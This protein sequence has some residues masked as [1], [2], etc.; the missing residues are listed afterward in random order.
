MRARCS[1]ITVAAQAGICAMT[2]LAAPLTVLFYDDRYN[3]T[4]DRSVMPLYRSLD[5]RLVPFL[6]GPPAGTAG[7]GI[8]SGRPG[9][10]PAERSLL[11]YRPGLKI[12]WLMGSALP[13]V[14]A[15]FAL[16]LDTDVVWLCDAK[17]VVAKRT[18]L[19]ADRQVRDD[20]VILFGEKGMWPPY[21][22]FHGVQLRA[23]AT[24]GYPPAKP[25]APF[26]FI[27]A[28]AALGRPHDLLAMYRCMK[29]RYA[30]FPNACPAGH[31]PDGALRYYQANRSWVPP[32]L[33]QPSR[34]TKFHGMALRG[35]NWGWEQGCFHMYYLE[36][37][38]GE[39]PDS[40]P[41][42]ELDRA[43]KWLLHL[44]GVSQ[45]SLVWTRGQHRAPADGRRVGNP[46]VTLRETGERPCALHANGPAK[47][48]LSSIWRW[49]N[50]PSAARPGPK[51]KGKE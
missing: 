28:G 31:G 36:Q 42:I 33:I 37:L 29:Q 46:R 17:E 39:L 23:N 48:M 10:G 40:C 12:D 16:L 47:A 2:T 49:W 43:G 21:Q 8:G 7:A 26:R 38:A 5:S 25:D 1:R 27:N 6:V 14:A 32:L 3:E 34:L 9:D 11:R 15:E 19:I 13:S 44:A 35:S 45:Q 18:A 41:P 51:H 22:E 50:D 4:R 20:S 24:A 30:G